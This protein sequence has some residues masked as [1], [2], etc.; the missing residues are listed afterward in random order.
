MTTL[1]GELPGPVTPG[2]RILAIDVVR[3]LAVLGI[4]VMNIVEFAQPMRAYDNPAYAGGDSG[5]DLWAWY[6]Q[7]TLFDG[8]MRALFSML[9]GAGIVLI[10]DRMARKGAVALTSD[11]LLRRC[12]WLVPFGIA[13]RFLLQWT[14]DILY[15]YGLLGAIAVAFR[16]LRPRTQILL[17]ILALTAF[18]PIGLHG[19]DKANEMR[20]QAEAAAALQRDGKEVP[21]ELQAARTRW[22]RRAESIPPKAADV[23]PELEAIRGGYVSVFRYRWDHHHEFQSAYVYY[24]FVWDVL[25]MMLVGMGLMR[26]GYFAGGWSTRAHAL[27]IGVGIA[28]A[29]AT[30]WWAR[31]WEATGFSLT[32]LELRAIHDTTYAYSRGLVGLAWA[33]ALILIVQRGV[34]RWLSAPLAAVGRMAF[35]NY[36]LQTICCTLLFFGYGLGLYGS[37]DRGPL[38]LVVVGV[39]AVQ[40]AFSLLWLRRFRYG[41]LEWAWRSLTWWQCQPMRR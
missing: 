41:P 7:V 21:P 4:L 19:Y 13:H 29:A 14:G 12:L 30:L 32:A 8:K 23:Q 39:S 5:W 2:E 26:L 28:A 16:S 3:G 6:L 33:S 20:T 17:G 37:I 10:A 22:L 40:V 38:L 31:C 25:G 27:L 18:V 9:F 1:P 24:Y 15:I 34:L 36:V 11:V 35:S